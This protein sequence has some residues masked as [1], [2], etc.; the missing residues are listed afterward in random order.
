MIRIGVVEDDEL[1]YRQLELYLKKYENE[2]S[3]SFH[4]AWYK[5]GLDIVDC[6]PGNIDI[7]F[8]DIEMNFMDGVSAGLKIR[9]LDKNV[10]I[11]FVTNSMKYAVKGYKVE[12][13]DYLLKPISYFVLSEALNK[14]MVRIAESNDACIYIKNEGNIIR[15]S[16]SKIAF[17]ESAGHNVIYHT[18]NQDYIDRNSIKNLEQQLAG[19]YFSRCNSGYLVNL[20]YVNCIQKNEVVVG[21]DW[22]LQISRPKKK[23]FMDDLAQYIGRN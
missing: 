9:E 15:L 3:L 18:R 10:I 14:A 17:I 22:K 2:K 13:M 19:N 20:A 21:D 4:I 6:Y 11:I 8:M 1:F 5:D 23:Q 16:L 12:A 7:V